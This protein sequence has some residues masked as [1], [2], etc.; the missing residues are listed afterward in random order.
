MTHATRP[1][2]NIESLSA[3]ANRQEI[4]DEVIMTISLL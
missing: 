4:S 2:K 1:H 3:V